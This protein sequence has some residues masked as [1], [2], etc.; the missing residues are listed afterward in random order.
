MSGS[1]PNSD[2]FFLCCFLFPIVSPPKNGWAN[3][4]VESDQYEFFS[5][6]WIFLTWQNPLAG[7]GLIIMIW[8]ITRVSVVAWVTHIALSGLTVTLPVWPWQQM[9]LTAVRT[10]VV[11]S[12]MNIHYDVTGSLTVVC[13]SHSGQYVWAARIGQGGGGFWTHST[14]TWYPGVCR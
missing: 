5:D 4:W 1:S 12:N 13:R 14:Y 3:R 11:A 6:F 2:F 8:S 10:G 7:R 9:R